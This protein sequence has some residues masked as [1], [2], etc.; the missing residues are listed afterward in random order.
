MK[1]FLPGILMV[2]SFTITCA[3]ASERKAYKIIDEKGNVTYS[4][5]PPTQAKSVQKVDISPANSGRGGNIENRDLLRQ[6]QSSNHADQR[7]RTIYS[8][9]RKREEA[10]Q[11]RITNLKAECNRNRGADCENPETLRLIEAQKI[12]GGRNFR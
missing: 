7:N 1:M 10:E 12:P 9:Q 11:Q 5:T 8:Q 6:Q 4:Q 3:G 2:I